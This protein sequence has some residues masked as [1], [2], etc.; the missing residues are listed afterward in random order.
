[1]S[2]K[3]ISYL[4]LWQT[5]RSVEWNN[6]SKISCRH[7]GEQYCETFFEFGP[8]VPEEMLFKNV[9]YQELWQPFCSTEWNHLCN[10]GRVYYEE[11]L[12]EIR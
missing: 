11:Q 4:E 6:L 5:L 3:D 9:S 7:H 12:C 8:V 2:F 1:M 10:F